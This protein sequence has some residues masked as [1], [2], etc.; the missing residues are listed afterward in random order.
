MTEQEIIEMLEH[1][2]EL[3]I[4]N[5]AMTNKDWIEELANAL[6]NPNYLERLKKNYAEYLRDISA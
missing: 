2:Y 6:T 5:C 1:Y 4:D 3:D